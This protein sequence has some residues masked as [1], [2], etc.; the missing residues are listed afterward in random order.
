MEEL[1]DEMKI[2]KVNDLELTI[3]GM[4]Q[5]L[6]NARYA[7]PHCSGWDYQK[8]FHDRYKRHFFL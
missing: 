5:E 2:E 8:S 4:V 6:K 1:N 3:H 7:P